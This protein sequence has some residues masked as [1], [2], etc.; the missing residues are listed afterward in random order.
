MGRWSLVALVINSI[1]GSSVFG[2]PGTITA[3]TG[4]LSPLAC[5]IAGAGIAAIIACFAEVSSYFSGAG[6]QYLYVR[7][8]YGRFAGIWMGWMFLLVR[9]TA[10]SSGA[11]LFARYLAIYLPNADKGLLRGVVITLL[12]G[13][14]ALVNIRGVSAGASLS[15]VFAVS[16]LLPLA[17]FVVVGAIFVGTHS[18]VSQGAVAPVAK[19]WADAILLLVF[20]YGGFEGSLVPLGEA[21][22]PRRDAPFA[23]FTALLICVVVYTSV[24][25]IVNMTLPTA[26]GHKTPL[27]AA[28]EIM[29]GR[30]GTA[31]MTLGTL[32]SI[33][34]YMTANLLNAPRMLYALG[35]RHDLPPF[36]AKVHPSFRTPHISIIVFGLMVWGFAILGDF[37]WNAML[38]AITRLVG[39]AAICGCVFIFRRRKEMEAK[40]PIAV[41]PVCAVLGIAFSVL[42]AFRMGPR[43][44][45][46]MGMTIV[47]ALATWLWAR[48]IELK[49]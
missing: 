29:L 48:R 41:A 49:V 30:G 43:E 6:G 2:L 44:L 23:L 21:K 32:V 38:S 27:A 46:I 20:A 28:A 22:D 34:G 42:L 3:L 26:S 16:K 8:G 1:I 24:Q 36:F 7:E 45:I 11:D 14:L 15:N 35:E 40:V 31:L 5:L 18:A 19:N 47:V 9:V 17:V 12:I 4:K 37:E 25:L 33:Y 13:G 10:A 39:F